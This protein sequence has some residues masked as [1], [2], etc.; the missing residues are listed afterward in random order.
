MIVQPT[1][2]KM[3]AGKVVAMEKLTSVRVVKG[4][5]HQQHKDKNIHKLKATCETTTI[6]LDF[7][8]Y[9]KIMTEH[10]K[11]KSKCEY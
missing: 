2:A 1:V 8:E 6:T 5:L 11:T 10:S 3:T 4:S 9:G 7:I